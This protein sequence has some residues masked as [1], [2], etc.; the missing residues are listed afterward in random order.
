MSGD[1]CSVYAIERGM[2]VEFAALL[3]LSSV[4]SPRLNPIMSYLQ[5]SQHTCKDMNTWNYQPIPTVYRWNYH[6]TTS[7]FS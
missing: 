5:H 1:R 3:L 4:S 7:Q 6:R 2:L